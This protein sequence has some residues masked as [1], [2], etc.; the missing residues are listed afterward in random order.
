MTFQV[1]PIAIAAA[2]L[3]S[4]A[5]GL[6]QAQEVR[7]P[8]IVQLQAEPAATYKGDVAGLAAT[9]P[10]AGAAFDY[11]SAPVQDY[12]QYLGNQK[13]AVLATIANAP[14]LADYDVVL[15]GFSVMLTDA[16]VLSLKNNAAVADIQADVARSYDTVTTANFL[17]LAKAGGLWSQYAGS[18]LVKGEDMVVGIVDGGIWPENPAFADRVDADGKPTFDSTATLAYTS[19]PVTFKGV[20]VSGEGFDPA[21]HCNNKLIGAQYFNAGFKASGRTLNW[22]DYISPRDSNI[23][24]NGTSTGH[25]GHGDHTASTAAG[26]ANNPVTMGGAYMGLASGMAPRA[27]VSSYKVCWTYD[28]TAEPD[29]T[30]A[31]NS[32]YNTDSIAAIDAAVKDGVNVINYS[33]SGSQTS[34]AD[35]VELAF[36]RASLAN[37]FVAASAGNSGPANAVAHISPWLTTVAASTH[38]RFY[39]ADVTLASG[40]KYTGASTNSTALP[41]APMIRAEDAGLGGG[42]AS[43][44]YSS[45]P[46]SGQVLLDPAKVAGKIVVCTRG[47]NARVDKS[48]AV[49]NAGGVG[50]IQADNGSGLVSEVHSVPSVHVTQADGNA[51]KAYVVAQAAAARAAIGTFYNQPKPAPIMASFSSRGPNMGDANILKPDLTAPGVDVIAH[52]TPALTPAQHAGVVNGSFVPPAAFDSYQGTSMSSP[53][54]A[55]VALL[56]RQA[57]PSWSPAA[58]K[59]AL[60][61]TGFTTLNDGV[62]GAS[63][64]LLPWSQGAGHIDP[65]KAIDPGLVYD[66]G[67]ADFIQ[68]NCK[69]NKSSVSPASDCT[70]FGTLDETYNLNLPSITVSAVQ[71]SAVVRRNVTNVGTSAAT[72]TATASVP[73]FTTVVSPSTLTLAP[74]ATGSFTVTLTNV[75]AVANTWNFGSLSWTD[76]THNVKIPV[77]AKIGV[78]LQVAVPEITSDKVS[79]SKLFAVKAGY[80]GVM[81]SA[82]GGLKEATVGNEVTLSAAAT[83]SAA[84]KTLCTTGANTAAVRV[85]PITVPANTV[86]LRAALFQED[87]NAGD[88]HDMGLLAPDG[89]WVYS[90]NDGSGESAQIASPAAGTYKACVVAYGSDAPTMRHRLNSWVVSTSDAATKLTVAVPAK[91]VQGVNTTVGVTWSGLAQNKR[92]LGGIQFK[93]AT[94]VVRATTVLRVETGS[95]SIPA[96]LAERAGSAKTAAN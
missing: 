32:C 50:M 37:V 69:V 62:A 20:C 52:V 64:G 51:I 78:P 22:S 3:L 43:L 7:R 40:V 79:G 30:N 6:T 91:V 83:S 15:N 13:S 16:E 38:D 72:Y 41:N 84:L 45:G 61:T 58:I 31:T 39:V 68:Y 53:H 49:L 29:G 56:L 11:H 93:D 4:G 18:S 70:T 36:Y 24:T 47:G 9:Q 48:L 28:N 34:S 27:R 76:G 23:G 96:A 54:V 21:K 66:A 2:I 92:Y 85:Y 55:G 80:N 17:G 89:T 82:K 26:N 90:G 86:V 60:M 44:C 73:G 46:V 67:K 19:A 95:A 14:V 42:N 88:D 75:N 81:T 10:A 71:G 74:G 94:G 35:P 5:A 65:N 63:N 12:V 8:Y 59:S 1:R 33:I 77:S 87:S 57:H 25:G